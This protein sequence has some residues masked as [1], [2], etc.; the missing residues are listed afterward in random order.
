MSELVVENA[1]PVRTLTLNRPT[2]LNAFTA[3][4][5]AELR[6]A[7]AA[8]IADDGVKVIVLTGEGRAFSSGQ[9]L[10]EDLPRDSQGGIDLG[11]ALERDYNP[12]IKQI[13]NS[14]KPTIAALN[15]PAVGASMN[16]ALA[17]DIVLAARSAT[18]QEAFAKIALIPD[19]GGTWLLPRLIG[20]KRAL[21]LMLTAEAVP[22]EEALR[23]G[24]VYKLYEDASFRDD[25]AAF[26]ARLAQGPGLAFRMIRE[27]VLASADND[28]DAQLA[29]EAALQRKA[30]ASHDFAEGVAA[31]L[32]KRAPQFQGR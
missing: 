5:H 19:A 6:A 11:P 13:V 4:L 28:L 12:L 27:A 32:A 31:F 2:K 3:S 9:D 17:C 15:G 30:G 16:I 29:L 1:G 26:A 23:M 14:P 20:P 18:L 8:A 7:L 22:A 21:A 10:T 24:L 25:V